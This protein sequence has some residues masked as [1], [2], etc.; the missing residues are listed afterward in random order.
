[1]EGFRLGIKLYLRDDNPNPTLSA[2]Q[3]PIAASRRQLSDAELRSCRPGFRTV[4]DVTL[5]SAR[6]RGDHHAKSLRDDRQR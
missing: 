6:A 5:T 4:N 2:T 1:L 3:H